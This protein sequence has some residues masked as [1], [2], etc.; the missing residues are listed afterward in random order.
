VLF[1]GICEKPKEKRSD[2]LGLAFQMHEF[3]AGL[4][5]MSFEAP[6]IPATKVRGVSVV[7]NS[8]RLL[9]EAPCSI[10]FEVER[11]HCKLKCLPAFC[12]TARRVRELARSRCAVLRRSSCQ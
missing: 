1:L 11:C 9:P 4:T 5:L 7:L 8:C 2:R 10:A 3:L 6:A 12:R